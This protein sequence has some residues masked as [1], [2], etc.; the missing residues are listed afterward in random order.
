MDSD[1][2]IDGPKLSGLGAA[3]VREVLVH[4]DNRKFGSNSACLSVF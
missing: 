4:Q 1:K 3:L 2:D